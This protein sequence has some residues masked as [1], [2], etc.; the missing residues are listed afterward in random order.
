MEYL[1][2]LCRNTTVQN[3]GMFFHT[4]EPKLQDRYVEEL[5]VLEKEKGQATSKAEQ[6]QLEAEIEA[7]RNNPYNYTASPKTLAMYRE[8]IVPQLLIPV[9]QILSRNSS[10]SI[11]AF[12]EIQ[13]KSYMNRQVSTEQLLIGIRDWI[14][15][16]LKEE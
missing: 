13:V 15:S 5:E 7:I 9:P 14:E 10:I 16:S 6:Q 1:S 11:R 4:L 8:K 2:Y 3:Q 12:L